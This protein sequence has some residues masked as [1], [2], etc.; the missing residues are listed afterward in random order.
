MKKNFRYVGNHFNQVITIQSLDEFDV[1]TSDDLLNFIRTS[2]HTHGHNVDFRST[3]CASA[4]EFVSELRRIAVDC[5]RLGWMPLVHI[6]THGDEQS[7]LIF[8]NGSE[9]SWAELTSELREINLASDFN[10]LVVC[11]ACYGFHCIG[12]IDILKEAPFYAVLAP[13]G[14]IDAGEIYATMYRFYQ[15]ALASRD[16]GQGFDALQETGLRDGYWFCIGAEHWY[17]RLVIGFAEKHCTEAG[18]QAR[19]RS[20][21][22]SLLKHSQFEHF[23][24]IK[25]NLVRRMTHFL[26]QEAYENFFALKEIP[27]NGQRFNTVYYRVLGKLKKLKLSRRI[28]L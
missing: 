24:S 19:A 27:S 26:R 11:T 6:E 22:R 25:R 20:I 28:K 14:V 8:A 17:E 23:G 21:H 3:R 5:R 7:G 9:L 1:P 15:R 18:L 16:L 2:C 10:L 12:Q 4:A 13:T